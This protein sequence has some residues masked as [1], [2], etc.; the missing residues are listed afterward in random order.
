MLLR[1]WPVV[2][3]V[4]ALAAIFGACEAA[5]T[6]RA[7]AGTD[8]ALSLAILDPYVGIGSAYTAARACGIAAL[9]AAWLA[10]A[11]GLLGASGRRLDAAH[12][13]AVVAV[14]ALIGLHVALPYTS[15]V[16]PY[17]GWPTALVPGHQPFGWSASARWWESVGI[18]AAYLF[19]VAVPALHL[20]AP[21]RRAWRV[22]HRVAGAAYVLTAGHALFLGSDF[23]TRGW[24]RAALLAAQVP[25][26][27]LL[28]VRLRRG[29]A[30]SPARRH[31]LR[32][33]SVVAAAAAVVVAAATIGVA[34]GEVAPGRSSDPV[35]TGTVPTGAVPIGTVR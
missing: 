4:V 6:A 18:V 27:A 20:L 34:V 31:A 30:S 21:R 7:R 3:V 26:L 15:A 33:G 35:P 22:L 11:T 2:G 24:P 1:R 16:V 23:L 8:A 14:V 25:L 17:G 13:C 28:A 10:V 9:A 32:V 29:V 12:R 5:L 19:V